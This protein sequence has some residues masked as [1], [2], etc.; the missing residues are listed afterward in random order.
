MSDSGSLPEENL[1]DQGSNFMPALF[2]HVMEILQ[3]KQI[4]T[5][6]NTMACG[7]RNQYDTTYRISTPENHTKSIGF[8][9]RV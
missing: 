6:L 7:G 1:S 3:V 8:T 2:K 5:S 4:K 9:L